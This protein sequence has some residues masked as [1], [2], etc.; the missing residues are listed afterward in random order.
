MFILYRH[1]FVF[2][3]VNIT[4]TYGQKLH[5]AYLST[6]NVCTTS[7][8]KSCHLLQRRLEMLSVMKFLHDLVLF[9]LGKIGKNVVNVLTLVVL[10]LFVRQ[11]LN[12]LSREWSMPISPRH[13]LCLATHCHFIKSTLK[14]I[15]IFFDVICILSVCFKLS[16]FCH[17]VCPH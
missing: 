15:F 5:K 1:A 12:S 3:F 8:R 13:Y 10:Y 6:S 17:A 2:V 14:N 9:E 11:K 7:T 16:L 4:V